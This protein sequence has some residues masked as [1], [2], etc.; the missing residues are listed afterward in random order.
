M[1]IN[2]VP[3]YYFHGI[4]SYDN[5]LNLSTKLVQENALSVLN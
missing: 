3:G 5:Y 4:Y 2:L 1:P